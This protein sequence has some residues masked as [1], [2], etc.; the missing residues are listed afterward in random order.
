MHF[1]SVSR[2]LAL[3][4]ALVATLEAQERADSVRA[5]T[6]RLP[7][8]VVTANRL[9]VAP[10]APT[11]AATV[12]SGEEIRAR[13][14]TNLAEVM[15]TVP[16]AAPVRSGSFGAVTTLFFRGGERDYVQV[17]IDGVP[18]NDP[19]GDVDLANI[20]LEDVER[21]E[22]V[23]GPASALYGSEAMTGVIQIFTRRGRGPA[24]VTAALRAGTYDTREGELGIEGGSAKAGLSA[25]VFRTQSDGILPFN[26]AYRNTAV[27]MSTDYAP[28][29][30]TSARLSARWHDGLF[31]FPTDG[32]GN[33]V[34]RNSFHR[35]RRLVASLDAGRRF[36]QRVEGRLLVGFNSARL[37]SDDAQDDAN[38]TQGFF[39]FRSHTSVRRAS[40]DARVNLYFPRSIVLSGG[41]ELVNEREKTS[42]ESNSEFGPS[43]T[44]E[45]IADRFNR[46]VYGQLFA[47]VSERLTV[48]AGGRVEDNEGFGTFAAYRASAGF[49]LPSN[50]RLRAG[51]GTAFKAPTVLEHYGTAG[52]VLGNPDLDPERS[53]SWE[54][55]VDQTLAGGRATL[56]VT[57]FDQRF[58]DMIQIVD[59]GADGLTYGNIDRATARGVEAEANFVLVARLTT[60]A[61]ASWLRTENEATGERQLR[62]PSFSSALVTSYVDAWGSAAVAIN[63]TG[64]R[65]DLDFSTFPSTRVTLD[66]YTT[67]D[68]SGSAALIRGAGTLGELSL[69]VRVLNIFDQEYEPVFNFDAPGRTVLV[70]GQVRVG[71]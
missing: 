53:R 38:D 36:N 20:T 3:S 11:A 9:D 55:G 35:E 47:N 52:F 5:D 13:G 21:I 31:H 65:D 63:Y 33:V 1:S 10:V 2:A 22:I 40:A 14:A 56:G 57:Y 68:L 7:T 28:D 15:A 41:A 25:S 23:R 44:P 6:A 50:T 71:R 46:A 62:R 48:T 37:Q 30:R 70:G 32:D 34:D 8:T 45:Q 16:S 60:R 29:E 12:V 27:R 49:R 64:K 58:R 69:S 19:G 26:N 24:T 66:P 17:L 4:L 59:D 18:V 42:S 61:S 39:A 43:V 51:V 54:A 67:V